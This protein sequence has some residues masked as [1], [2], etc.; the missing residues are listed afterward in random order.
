MECV[1]GEFAIAE[2]IWRLNEFNSYE[3]YNVLP[4]SHCFRCFSSIFERERDVS[5]LCVFVRDG[6]GSNV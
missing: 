4:Q 5:I 3:S 1:L 2:S 6:E